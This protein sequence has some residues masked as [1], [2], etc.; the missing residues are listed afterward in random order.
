MSSLT[1]NRKKKREFEE[2]EQALISIADKILSKGGEAVLTMDNLIA[3]TEYSKGTVYKHF[4]SKDDLLAAIYFQ[5]FQVLLRIFSKVVSLPLPTR[6][7]ELGLHVAHSLF[8]R[9]Y[10][11]ESARLMAP[12]TKAMLEK[13]SPQ[14]RDKLEALHQKFQELLLEPLIQEAV[15]SGGPEADAGLK[16]RYDR[17]R[18]PGAELRDDDHHVRDE[19]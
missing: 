13:V 6:E 1:L 11:R 8:D 14:R 2:R 12:N 15:D 10:F 3:H 4:K 17:L 19:P 16:H 5:K 9:R 7:R 18:E